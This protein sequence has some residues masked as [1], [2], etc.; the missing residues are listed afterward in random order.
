MKLLTE[1]SIPKL[2]LITPLLII[3]VLTA[4]FINF[5]IVKLD[6]YFEKENH[7]FIS[8]YIANEESQ[9]QA[10]VQQVSLLLHYS[11]NRLERAIKSELKNRVDLAY[12][13]ANFIYD[14][15]HTTMTSSQ[16]KQQINDALSTMVWQGKKNYVWITD[17]EGN[18]YLAA[19]EKFHQINMLDY[20]DTEGR[21]IILEEIQ[22]VRR[23]KEGFIKSFFS[24]INDEQMMYVKDLGIY[25]WFIGSAIHINDA[26]SK[27]KESMFR[28]IM[29]I[30]SDA[31]GFI[32]LFDEEGLLYLSD[33]AKEYLSADEIAQLRDDLKKDSDHIIDKAHAHL[34]GEYFAPFGW[35]LFHGFDHERL[36]KVVAQQKE[37]LSKDIE[38]EFSYIIGFS[39]IIA[40]LIGAF[41]ILASRRINKIFTNYREEVRLR[42]A[43]LQEWTITL[44]ERVK[45]EV[46]A[47]QE[48]EKMLIQQSK[49]AAM[50]DMISMIAHQW[51]QPL[52]QMSYVFMNIEGAYEYKEL[53]PEYLDGKIQEGT[54]LLEY[55][56]HTIDDFRNFFR[57]DKERESLSIASVVDDTLPLIAKSLEAHDIKYE[58]TKESDTKL[59]IYRNELIQVLLNIMKNAKDVILDNGVVSGVI[60]IIVYETEDTVIV[61]V[62]D[63]GGGIEVSVLPNIFDPYFS[64]KD[65]SSG[66]GLGL[67]MSKTI[68]EEHLMGKLLCENSGAGACFSIILP[69]HHVALR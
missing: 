58:V 68:V 38:K 15:Y 25:N 39:I 65:S 26:R 5:F 57:P 13:S 56:S 12:K 46:S 11:D 54:K 44:E 61:K 29:S 63:N 10:W 49:M 31:S 41:S 28:L 21:A 8:E 36:N 62:C 69:K 23:H 66:T 34:Y 22:K 59:Y 1:T 52:N 4:I 19:N 33:A 45:K 9:S 60:S 24:D 20:T 32:V 48:K 42:E 18:N 40:L 14:K 43:R 51:R 27:L 16:I 64:T 7:R 67:Y 35:Y 55:M 47:H 6:E 17:F 50:G 53:T 3:T 37:V 2:I 30:P